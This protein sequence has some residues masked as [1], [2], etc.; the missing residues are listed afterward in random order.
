[1]FSQDVA[2]VSVEGVCASDTRPC[3]AAG[4]NEFRAQ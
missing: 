3:G 4:Q 2:K 1:M